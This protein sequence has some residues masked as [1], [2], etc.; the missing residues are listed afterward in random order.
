M[1]TRFRLAPVLLLLIAG[2][3][4]RSQDATKKSVDFRTD[5]AP[6]LA[7]N[8]QSCHTGGAPPADLRLDSPAA[9]LQGSISGK[10]I[11]PGKSADSLLVKRITA[12]TGVGMPPSGPLSDAQVALITAWI[13]QGAKMD[14]AP[15]SD[16]FTTN[17]LPIFQSNCYLCHSGNEPKGQLHLDSKSLALKGGASGPA[18]IPG[19]SEV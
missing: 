6:I 16:Y 5:I 3:Q 17:V 9:I 13:D 4:V 15:P 19:N 1:P 8:C 11:I 14:G 12:K 10:I 2:I 7:K 18:I